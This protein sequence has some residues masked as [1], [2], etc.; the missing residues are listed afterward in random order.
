MIRSVSPLSRPN[1]FR[2]MDQMVLTACRVSPRMRALLLVAIAALALAA[3]LAGCG[4]RGVV[5]PAPVT[6]VGA[7]PKATLEPATPALKLKGDPGA[8]RKVFLTAGC[9]GCHT[10]ADAH[11]TGTVGPNLDD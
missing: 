2:F 8:G 9:T 3:A 6:V 7:L 5:T 4:A 11:A 1:D 10:L